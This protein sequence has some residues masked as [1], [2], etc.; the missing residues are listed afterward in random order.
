M[1]NYIIVG[2][3]A[4]GTTAAEHI[5]KIDPKGNIIIF[6]DE[7]LPFY[8]RI[9]LNEYLAGDMNKES[10][11]VKQPKWYDQQQIKLKLSTRIVG[12]DT[13]RR[14][15]ITDT[16][17]RFQYDALLIAAGSHSFI[18]PIKGS[19]KRGVFTLRNIRDVHQVLQWADGSSEVVLIG[20][21][22]LGLEAG[23]ALRKRGKK[24]S[25]VEFFPR[26]LPRQLDSEG[27]RRLQGIMEEMGFSFRL[28][29]KTEA[30]TGDDS[31]TGVQLEDGEV[32]SSEMVIISAGV[33][34][35]LELA[36]PLGLDSDKGIQVDKHMKTNQ[37]EIYAAG[38]AAEF[39][40]IT[41]GIWPAAMEQGRVAGTNM[42]G[43]EAEYQG[44]TMS[45]VLKVVGI[46]LAS[47]GDIDNEN[48]MRSHS[49]QREG[50]Y[51]KIVIK[52]K[53]ITG[54]IMLGET[55]SFHKVTQAM[56]GKKDISQMRDL[57]LAEGFD[58][59]EV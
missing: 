29:A 15:V 58:L 49:V 8:W 34:S 45:N 53:Y 17:E 26:L 9:R 13:Q 41:Y 6:T 23:N 56:S 30:I 11:I 20:G 16:E 2:N 14:N 18:P 3:G 31:V 39:Q 35:N 7:D 28:G 52:D 19:D 32:L 37:S 55:K 24:V 42:A 51:K 50:V 48:K 12:G 59:Q 47:A 46:D 57:L 4:A 5:R 25:V 43:K 44:T 27:A 22:L 33:R 54:C 36:R 40:G 1:K 38:D 10:L 21:G